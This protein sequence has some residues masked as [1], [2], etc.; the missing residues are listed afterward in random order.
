MM[1]G[2]EVW[3][4][5]KGYEGIYEVSTF[6]RVKSLYR[7][8]DSSTAKTRRTTTFK[9]RI[10][11]TR[12]GDNG[13]L[14]VSLYSN[15]VP[16][17]FSVHKLVTDAFLGP[18]PDGMERCHNDGNNKNNRLSNLRYDTPKNNN[19]DKRKHGT[20]LQGSKIPC[21]KLDESKVAY[22]LAE[23]AKGRTQRSFAEQFGV[24]HHTISKVISRERWAHV[25]FPALCTE[26][27][28]T[29]KTI[30]TEGESHG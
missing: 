25:P 6:G 11:S 26:A 16:T 4:T 9:E 17:T 3:T 2:V 30:T 29:R 5:V 20:H 23:H 18:M 27:S 13:C 1:S 12:E 14:R 7:K 15:G 28:P 24:C 22:I 10:L 19:A 21:A 8:V